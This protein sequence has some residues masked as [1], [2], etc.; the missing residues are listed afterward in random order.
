MPGTV[1]VVGRVWQAFCLALA[2][3][4]AR[5]RQVKSEFRKS[6]ERHSDLEPG[7]RAAWL[8]PAQSVCGRLRAE[9]LPSR[10]YSESPVPRPG[11][12]D[13][14]RALRAFAEKEASSGSPQAVRD[15]GT[16]WL[17]AGHSD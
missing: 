3:F 17:G 15:E 8:S 7:E 6:P 9:G 11:T 12:P 10:N 5:S 4:S 13:I 1:L 2:S 16:R 14:A